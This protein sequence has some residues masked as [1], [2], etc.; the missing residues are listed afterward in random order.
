MAK[1]H[2]NPNGAGHY[3]TLPDGRAGWRK[4][5]DGKEIYLSARTPKELQ[6]K[7]RKYIDLPIITEKYKVSEWFE[8][9]IETDVKSLKKPAT[10]NQYKSIYYNHINPVIGS[11]MIN[12]IKR[13][14]IKIVIAKMNEGGKSTK[15]MK[16]AKNVMRLGFESALKDRKIVHENPVVNI[17]IPAKQAKPRKVLS[18]EELSK[19]FKAMENSRWKWSIKFMLVTGVRRGELLAL[20]WSDVDFENKRL[21]IDE[22]NSVTGLGDTKSSKIHYVPLSEKA[23]EYLKHQVDMLRSECNPVA[24]N[25]NGTYKNLKG[26]DVLV[27]PTEKGT[28][29]KPN[30]FYHTFVR[31]AKKAGV[32]ASPHCLRHTFVFMTRN[33]LS[34]KEIQAILGHDES[35]TTLEIYG[36]ILD[37]STDKTARQI[38]E[39]FSQ[40]DIEV[41]KLN[42][43]K[44]GKIIP[45]RARL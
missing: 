43:K 8:E 41:E 32:K 15:T 25:E 27:F 14:D 6:A 24:M 35:T 45:F 20:K 33:K 13:S 10:Y 40:V 37:E 16:H 22:S 34:L 2:K 3:Y 12:S 18:T 1:K 26:T 4:M 29:I 11:R 38:D 17:E 21:T 30:T 28:M 5:V 9:W 42:K 31:F 36:N 23:I 44:D 19:I 39:I 7:V